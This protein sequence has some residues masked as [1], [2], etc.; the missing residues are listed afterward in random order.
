MAVKLLTERH[1]EIFSLKGV[2]I[3]SSESIPVKCHNVVNLMHIHVIS[4]NVE[5]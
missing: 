2:C 1:L 4:N 3:G 5:F